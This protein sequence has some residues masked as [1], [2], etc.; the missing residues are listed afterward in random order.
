VRS[1]AKLQKEHAFGHGSTLAISVSYASIMNSRID[2]V[3]Q[4]IVLL[5]L[6]WA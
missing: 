2:P 1:G 6:T 3:F 5:G 4:P